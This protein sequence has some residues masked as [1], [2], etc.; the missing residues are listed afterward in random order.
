M[1]LIESDIC[2]A[3]NQGK[4]RRKAN[5]TKN[6]RAT[7]KRIT[8]GAS[9]VLVKITSFGKGLNHVKSHLDYITRNGNVEMENDRGEIFE[10]RKEVNE[11]FEDWKKDFGNSS[12]HK[13]QRD[14]MHMVLS[15]PETVDP[16]SVKNATRQFA[17]NNFGK[18]HE[19]LFVLH[20]DTPQPHCHLT[21]KCRGFDGKR[22]NPRKADLQRWREDFAEKLRNQGVDAEATPRCSRGVVKKTISNII[23]H[24][25]QGDKTHR[26][27]ESK[28]KKEKIKEI[29]E[30]ILNETK[31]SP[32]SPKPWEMAIQKK[33][34]TIREKWLAVAD[35]L[36][37]DKPAITF[38][39][40]EA[41]NVRPNYNTLDIER[42]KKWQRA[43]AIYQSGL[44]KS[45]CRTAPGTISSMRK[46]SSCP[47]VQH[48]Q[49][50][51][52]LLRENAR[53]SLGACRDLD[54]EMRRSRNGSSDVP[55]DEE[56]IGKDVSVDDKLLAA[57]IRGF[58][59]GMP[60]IETE[61]HQIKLELIRKFTKQPGM[62]IKPQDQAPEQKKGAEHTAPEQKERDIEI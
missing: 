22:L 15:M 7:V 54:F 53:N 43:A 12:R 4:V 37:K 32:I 56:Q 34:Q 41:E 50:S 5:I 46:L 13:N 30:E 52:M 19:Y 61:R 20:S 40:K 25:E 39:Q 3:L 16:E 57:S 49:S 44:E 51:K 31:G 21:V 35:Y 60:S 23:K 1:A 24:I 33:Q 27:R 9:E 36:E 14:T 55:G 8:G 10:G 59:A 47:M 2:E 58:V 18:N 11:L 38:N 29:V 26:P 48:E 28:V 62:K 45:G 6:L 17:E 42:T